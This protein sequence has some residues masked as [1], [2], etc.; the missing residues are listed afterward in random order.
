M[1]ERLL[2]HHRLIVP[3]GLIAAGLV[4]PGRIVAGALDRVGRRQGGVG[5]RM[6]AHDALI[7]FLPAL[8]HFL[9]FGLAHHRVETRAELARARSEE[10]P[11][12]LPSLISISYAD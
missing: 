7:L 6:F 11:S 5:R 1:N 10:H 12:E 8:F 2:D 4:F 3:A 9:E